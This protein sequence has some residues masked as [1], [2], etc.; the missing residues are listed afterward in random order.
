MNEVTSIAG[1]ERLIHTG[2]ERDQL[3]DRDVVII[4]TELVANPA[5]YFAKLLRTCIVELDFALYT[6]QERLIGEFAGIEIG[7]KY[8]EQVER[9]LELF[10][11]GQTQKIDSAV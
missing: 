6:P 7:S 4:Q 3:F 9:N 8:H 10:A 2:D 1:A 5:E 11:A